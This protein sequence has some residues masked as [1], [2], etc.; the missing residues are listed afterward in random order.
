M[1]GIIKKASTKKKRFLIGFYVNWYIYLRILF[2]GTVLRIFDVVFKDYLEC[3]I[4]SVTSF[5]HYRQFQSLSLSQIIS[6]CEI[7]RGIT[8]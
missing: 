5:S 2:A 6:Y 4:T 8:I 7:L 3:Y 1:V